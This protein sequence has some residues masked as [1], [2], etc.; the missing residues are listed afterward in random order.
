M[1]SL[2]YNRTIHRTIEG[3]VMNPITAND[4][5]TRGVSA[6]EGHLAE[7]SEAIISVRG[8]DRFVVM[9]LE[10]Y[11]AMRELELEAAWM[12][13]KADLEAGRYRKESVEEHLARISAE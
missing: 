5:K 13:V 9:S 4:L 12:R 11:R 7:A 2:A 10:H 3:R 1:S 8:R 6:I